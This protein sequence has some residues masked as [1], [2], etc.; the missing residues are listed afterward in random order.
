MCGIFDKLVFKV[1]ESFDNFFVH[2]VISLFIQ[3]F[4]GLIFSV[5]QV[6]L[7]LSYLID[8][9]HGFLSANDTFSYFESRWWLW[10][11][12]Q[13]ARA[14]GSSMGSGR[15]LFM[16]EKVQNVFILIHLRIF[17][18]CIHILILLICSESY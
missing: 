13:M 14:K 11:F 6:L 15:W 12:G 3:R 2:E 16:L 18:E 17:K 10:T 4:L 7:L 9:N 1:I 5:E 8:E